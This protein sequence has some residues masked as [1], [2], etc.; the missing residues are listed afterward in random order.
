MRRY[1]R[2]HSLLA[3]LVAVSLVLSLYVPSVAADEDP[4][5]SSNTSDT[6][7]NAAP[8]E[9]QWYSVAA[10][11]MTERGIYGNGYW[12]QFR[13]DQPTTRAMMATIC[14]RLVGSPKYEETQAN[15]FKDVLKDR[16]YTDG[17]NW[18]YRQGI[19]DGYYPTV[20]GLNDNM[21]REQFAVVIWKLLGCPDPVTPLPGAD[22]ITPFSDAKDIHSWAKDAVSWLQS[23]RMM[24]GDAD[25]N[26]GPQRICTMADT[27]V[28]ISRYL[29]YLRNNIDDP[30][31]E[32]PSIPETPPEINPEPEIPSEPETPDID[33][34]NT[35]DP[36]VQT[37]PSNPYKASNFYKSGGYLHY[38]QEGVP[39]YVGIDVSR[40]Q[41]NIDWNAVAASG[42]QFAIIRCGYRGYV[43]PNIVQDEYFLK[44]INGA[45]AAGIKVGIYFFSQAITEAEAIEEANQTL[46][47]I[48]NYDVTFPIVFDWEEVRKDNSRSHNVSGKVMTD[49][50]VA[51]CKTIEQAGYIPMTYGSPSKVYSSL[52]L[53][54][55]QS[56]PF[57]LAHYTIN[58][59][60]TN[61]KYK[62]QMWQYSST[63][64]V[65]GINGNTDLDICLT[66]FSE[67]RH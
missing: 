13:P 44:N 50:A 64:T 42:V 40:Y 32:V 34:S 2:L 66:D 23:T 39:S 41:G 4:S 24:A 67:Y 33:P 63:G 65:P 56:W 5:A 58:W 51:F 61:F 16:W 62:Y 31:P 21:T 3:A 26:F 53:S 27:A 7:A 28:L 52:D 60:P 9:E 6:S 48:K 47:W 14:Y 30:E 38:N 59:N 22:P 15:P 17:V 55:L 12:M 57:W 49:C 43:Y 37:I 1:R 36:P 25:G 8:E 11:E 20:F 54:R 29:N 18:V 19:M 46:R 35:P 45:L 10:R